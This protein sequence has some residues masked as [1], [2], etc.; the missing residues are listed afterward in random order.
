MSLISESSFMRALRG[1]PVSPAPVW[2]M[3]Q[4]GRY[5]PEYRAT[6]AQAGSFLD[7]CYN[8]ALATEVTLQPIRRFQF[9]AAILFSDILVIPWA[10][11]R[12]VRFEEGVGP[13]L[14]PIETPDEVDALEEELEKVVERLSP[15][16]EAV[17]RIRAALP[18]ETPLIGFIGAPW[19]LAT[20]MIAGRGTPDQA[21]A[22]LF[23]YTY[24]EAFEKLIRI[25]EIAGAK[26]LAA[27][28]AAGANALKVFDSWAGSL[29]ASLIDVASI[30]PLKR[31]RAQLLV[32][33][34]DTPVILF[35]RGV[36]GAY[37]W[38]D[39]EIAPD[40]LAL[41]Q[42]VDPVWAATTLTHSKALQGNLDPVLMRAPFEAID[43][44]V[45]TLRD[46]MRGRGHILNLGHGVTPDSR[47][48][49]VERLLKQWRRPQ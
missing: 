35:P 43:R 2:I 44:E 5:L 48:E 9:D 7:L 20:Y 17:E 33:A 12:S 24:P 32:D 19:T 47:I 23:A 29:P 39:R 34:P 31:L 38:Y 42:S 18:P 11:G 8:P 46:A 41:D 26:L 15:V 3:R 30:S 1:E 21:P 16:L 28:A 22:K 25:L 6:R 36:G 13:R 37:V 45:E 14:D 49:N 40:G 27:Q 4:A 10:L